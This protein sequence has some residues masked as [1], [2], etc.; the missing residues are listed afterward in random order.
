VASLLLPLT[1]A[2]AQ[3]D[4]VGR[5]PLHPALVQALPEPPNAEATRSQLDALT[6]EPAHSMTGYSR[7]K[8]PHWVRITDRCDTRETVLRRD[9]TDVLT[10]SECRATTGT[11]YSPYDGKTLTS[12]STVDIDHMVPLAN[13]WRSGADTWDTATR[14][15]FAND[16]TNP[17]LIAVSASSN[18]AKGDQSPDQWKPPR[19]TYWC[20]YARAWTHVKQVYTLSVTPAEHDA[21]IEMLNTCTADTPATPN[22]P[23][24]G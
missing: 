11:W 17:Q 12:A 15:Q 13:A 8:F 23:A 1:A 3:A 20:T 6:V 22:T 2:P 18:R 4:P 19:A 14:R 16:L 5:L 9:G 24:G 10:D 7:E 21:L